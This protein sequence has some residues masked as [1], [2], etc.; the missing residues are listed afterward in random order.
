MFSGH[1]KTS[2]QSFPKEEPVSNPEEAG[3]RSVP[4]KKKKF[5]LKEE[6]LS[7]GPEEALIAR[8]AAPRKSKSSKSYLRKIRMD[9]TLVE[10]NSPQ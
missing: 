2:L 1:Y 3:N 8:A 5:S 6:P 9:S 4:K 10:Y 7:S